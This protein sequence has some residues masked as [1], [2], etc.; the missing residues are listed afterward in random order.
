MGHQNRDFLLSFLSSEAWGV[1]SQEELRAIPFMHHHCSSRRNTQTRAHFGW[2]HP[3]PHPPPPKPR[4]A[5]VFSMPN[6]LAHLALYFR[7]VIF[8]AVRGENM[9]KSSL[10]MQ[11]SSGERRDM[12]IFP[13]PTCTSNVFSLPALQ[14][15][16][17][18]PPFA[19]GSR[20]PWSPTA[21]SCLRVGAAAA[22]RCEQQ[23]GKRTSDWGRGE[24]EEHE[25]LRDPSHSVFL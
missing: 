20:Q 2:A 18:A 9:L 6:C 11:R 14:R 5:D 17:F 22:A 25:V 15:G 8:L 1:S 16:T 21:Q 4:R 12:F 13:V 10:G 23:G 19:M 24:E 7:A 3:Q